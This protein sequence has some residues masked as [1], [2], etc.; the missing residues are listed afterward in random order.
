MLFYSADPSEGSFKKIIQTLLHVTS[1]ITATAIATGDALTGTLTADTDFDI[2]NVVIT[3]GTD[4]ITATAYD[5][6]TGEISIASVTDDVTIIAT[7]TSQG[8]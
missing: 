3:M 4:D 2:A 6:T 1:S 5:S 7:A 8:A